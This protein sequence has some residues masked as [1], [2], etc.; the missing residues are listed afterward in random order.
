MMSVL[1]PQRQVHG[2]LGN[3]EPRHVMPTMGAQ[4]CCE[5]PHRRREPV[6]V[7]SGLIPQSREHGKI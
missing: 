1:A 7:K 6:H 4:E 3:C 2:I 5:G